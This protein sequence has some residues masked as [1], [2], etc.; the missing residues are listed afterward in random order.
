MIDRLARDAYDRI[1]AIYEWDMARNMPFDDA[2]YYVRHVGAG[3][4]L[5]L[6]CGSGRITLALLRAGLDVVAVDVS[7]NMLAE[8][9]RAARPTLARLR[10]VQM[11]MRAWALR[12]RFGAALMP[13]SL[14][15]YVVDREDRAELLS[16]IRNS[17]E[18]GGRLI[19]DAFIPKPL[20]RP[21]ERIEDYV[22]VLPDG[23]TLSRWKIVEQTDDPSMRIMRRT[24]TLSGEEPFTTTTRIR[25]SNPAELAAELSEQGFQIEG[26]DFDYG[27]TRSESAAQFA[28]VRAQ[29]GQVSRPAHTKI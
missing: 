22:R 29:V 4:V 14:I 5:E 7:G 24:Y 3:P 11:D 27:E 2:A 12:A 1:A 25:L 21:G 15:T 9:R 17:L 28:T 13:Y 20:V 8:L 26:I 6:G 18:P 19:A 16:N 10:A 23:R